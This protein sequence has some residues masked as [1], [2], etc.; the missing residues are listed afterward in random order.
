[1][2]FNQYGNI[3]LPFGYI[4]QVPGPRRKNDMVTLVYIH[5]LGGAHSPQVQS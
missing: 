3:T 2:C 5:V 1:M 4:G